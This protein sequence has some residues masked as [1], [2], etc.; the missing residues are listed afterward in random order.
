MI[1][2][3][4]LR[5]GTMDPLLRFQEMLQMRHRLGKSISWDRILL[6]YAQDEFDAYEK[7][8]VKFKQ[9]RQSIENEGNTGVSD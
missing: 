2:T 9:F 4:E 6:L 7:F 3:W 5:P 1:G 8:F